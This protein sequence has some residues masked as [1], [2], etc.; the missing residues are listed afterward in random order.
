MAIDGVRRDEKAFGDLSIRQPFGDEARD[1][2]FGPRQRRPTVRLRFG[3]D[4]AP[5]NAE[6]AEAAADA[7]GVPGRAEFAVE[8]GVRLRASMAASRSVA[9]SSTRLESSTLV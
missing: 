6:F 1:G 9:I 2:Q 7:A 5:P 8:G 3:G 4:E